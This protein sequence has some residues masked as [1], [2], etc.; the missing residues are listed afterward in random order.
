M[1]NEKKKKAIIIGCGVAGPSV[2]LALKK[3]GIE[4]EIF[5]ESKKPHHFGILSI[6]ANGFNLLKFFG[7]HKHVKLDDTSKVFFYKSDGNLFKKLNFG[8]ELRKENGFGQ[9][10][11]RRE[12]LIQILSDKA[13]EEQIPI[14]YNKS[15]KAI[16]ETKEKITATFEDG[17]EVEGD[18]LLGCD[19]IFSKTRKVTF[20]EAPNPT[21]SGTVWVGADLDS[22][23][24]KNFETNAFHM[25]LGEKA[26][27]GSFVSSNN[28]ITWWSNVP[29]TKP[30]VGSELKKISDSDWKN[31]LIG[32][33]KDD[34][35]VILEMITNTSENYTK[36]P[37]YDLIHLPQW[38]KNLICLV[39]DAAHGIS[40]YMGQ[41]AALAM[42]DAV[43][44]AKCLRD[45]QNIQQAFSKFEELRK[46]RVEKIIKL[47]K[48]SGSTLT[49]TSSIKRLFR[50][51][52][53]SLIL[54][55]STIKKQNWIFS[56][57]IDWDEKL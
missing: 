39:G 48:Q 11:I 10:I 37:I 13:I 26:Y 47:S 19:G 44:L 43:V 8:E 34:Q 20:P 50:S 30:K 52:I 55:M 42:E 35:K 56:H 29:F 17:S 31:K 1:N 3:I 49:T 14:S 12:N 32:L 22:S 25:T 16:H 38:S 15:L 24:S 33:H 40:P 23:I 57:K 6:A 46:P 54:N 2:A 21:F 36:I 51:V 5:E 18:F 45:I 53:L 41:G 27:F 4:S 28:K 7:V 9:A